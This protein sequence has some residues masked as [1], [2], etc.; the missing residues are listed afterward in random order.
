MSSKVNSFLKSIDNSSAILILLNEALPASL[1]LWVPLLVQSLKESKKIVTILV[2]K[3]GIGWASLSDKYF[4]LNLH[5][6]IQPLRQNISIPLDGG[7]DSLG[8][9]SY[10]I[11]KGILEVSVVPQDGVLSLDKIKTSSQG[12]K[13]NLVIGVGVGAHHSTLQKIIDAKTPILNSSAYFLGVPLQSAS[14]KSKLPFMNEIVTINEDIDDLLLGLTRNIVLNEGKPVSSLDMVNLFAYLY[15]YE[16]NRYTSSSL[17]SEICNITRK[18]SVEDKTINKAA[19]VFSLNG[20]EEL[21]V[22]YFLTQMK[23][24]SNSRF[25][26]F[27][28]D[29][30]YLEQR[31]ISLQDAIIASQHIPMV[32]SSANAIICFE[33]AEATHYLIVKGSEDFVKKFA[34]K[35]GL[36]M[37]DMNAVGRVYDIRKDQLE[38]DILSLA[39]DKKE[40]V[41]QLLPRPYTENIQ[42]EEDLVVDE[43]KIAVSASLEEQQV[44]TI[45]EP[46]DPIVPVPDEYVDEDI[47]ISPPLK[48]AKKLQKK[49]NKGLNFSEIAKKMRESITS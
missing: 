8:E 28:L 17:Y 11:V 19:Q 37:D 23:E 29:V 41:I 36:A 2:A 13:Y 24:Y 12:I 46:L 3:E 22:S 35:Y 38:R 48:P 15:T 39:T 45:E 4:P 49:E 40:E 1:A 7:T 44:D 31:R 18:I 47:V 10:E 33:E 5:L 26:Y 20:D 21:I 34:L 32:S 30:S 16:K 43:E 9:V 25:K 42:K 6:E 14:Y 27:G